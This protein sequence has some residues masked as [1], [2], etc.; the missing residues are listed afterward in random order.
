MTKSSN[1]P[2]STWFKQQSIRRRN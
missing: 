2:T 1:F